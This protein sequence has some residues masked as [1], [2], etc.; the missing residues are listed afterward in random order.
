MNFIYSTTIPSDELTIEEAVNIMSPTA[1]QVL[2]H[3]ATKIVDESFNPDRGINFASDIDT[4][5]CYELIEAG[6]VTLTSDSY[7]GNWN[8]FTNVDMI[9][10]LGH[11]HPHHVGYLMNDIEDMLERVAG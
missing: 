8:M 4:D 1:F 9:E 5:D 6:L 3:I 2:C 11:E 7:E 10:Y